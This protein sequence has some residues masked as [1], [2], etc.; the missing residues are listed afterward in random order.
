M[1]LS[2]LPAAEHCSESKSYVF[3]IF[4]H[5]FKK[6]VLARHSS[7][8]IK[9][10]E[11][12]RL[13]KGE[14][15]F[16]RRLLVAMCCLEGGQWNC[17]LGPDRPWSTCA[18]FDRRFSPINLACTHLDPHFLITCHQSV[19]SISCRNSAR[20]TAPTRQAWIFPMNRWHYCI[21]ST[22]QCDSAS[23]TGQA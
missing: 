3:L 5:F 19:S 13:P 17:D 8:S 20:N 23:H 9:M 11:N 10:M 15:S 12:K 18:L 22:T 4:K 16:L 7:P 6:C 14:T 2:I 1:S 21:Y